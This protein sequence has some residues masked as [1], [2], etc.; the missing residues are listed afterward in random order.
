VRVAGY[1][2]DLQRTLYFL[3]PGESAP[4]PEVLA[5][6]DTTWKAIEVSAAALKPGVIG[7]EVDALARKVITDAG[8]S[9]FL[10]GLG[11][12][13]GRV[14]HDGGALLG[15]EW[16]RYGNTPNLR[17]EA[18]QVFTL[19]PSV[20]VPGYGYLGLEEDVLV[21]EQGAVFLSQPQKSLIVK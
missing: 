13:V 7:K 14:V 9:E 1:C 20:R 6:F 10:Y 5:A 8:Y 3:R 21:T 15:P 11:H 4:P 16:E 2:S 19:E 18:G 12:Q 17:V